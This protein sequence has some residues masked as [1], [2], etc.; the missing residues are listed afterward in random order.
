M[1]L[2]ITN[3]HKILG[4]AVL[5]LLLMTIGSSKAVGAESQI[6]PDARLASNAM[7]LALR[8]VEIDP[9]VLPVRFAEGVRNI[10]A[11][12]NFYFKGFFLSN[13][14]LQ[15]HESIPK[16]PGHRNLVGTAMFGDLFGR[17]VTV[18][19]SVKYRDENGILVIYQAV[20]DY[21]SA[22]EPEVMW[23]VVPEE[24]VLSDMFDGT[25]STEQIQAFIATAGL[26]ELS[27]SKM[28]EIQPYYVFG[29]VMD[30]LADDDTIVFRA[31][32]KG[33]R[34]EMLHVENING[35]QIGIYK[36]SFAPIDIGVKLTL[37]AELNSVF[38][39]NSQMLSTTK[40]YPANPLA[41]KLTNQNTQTAQPA[42]TPTQGKSDL[43]SLSDINNVHRVH[44]R[45][46]QLGFYEGDI[47][48]KWAKASRVALRKFKVTNGLEDSAV[49]DGE[50]QEVLFP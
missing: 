26:G 1:V 24:R 49:W 8:H 11:D 28:K 13:L 36:G 29:I 42:T 44:M 37:S 16:K 12:P 20:A 5:F 27:Q 48:T 40:A 45:L 10:I 17:T 30:R 3:L 34:A 21:V 46:S 14:F 39:K 47:D 35:W 41:K 33:E 31:T 6:T 19:F 22:I 32:T 43:I 23:F 9:N 25:K 4:P 50:T 7:V 2:K 18:V 38:S 15:K